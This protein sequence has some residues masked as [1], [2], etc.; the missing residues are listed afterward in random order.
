MKYWRKNI[1]LMCLFASGAGTLAQTGGVGS[2]FG[3]GIGSRDLALGGSNIAVCDFSTAPYWNPSR[4]ARSEQYSITG[5]HT[6]LFDT[7]V[8]YQ[9][10]GIVIPTLDWGAIGFGVTRLGIDGIEKRDA[11]NLLLDTIGDDRLGLRIGYGRA[12]GSLDVGLSLSLETHSLDTYKATSTP[13]LDIAATKMVTSP[14]RWC[15]NLS[16]TLVGRNVISPSMRLVDESVKSPFELQVGLSTKVLLSGESGNALGI[17]GGYS[18]AENALGIGSVGLECS[19]F[20][21]LKLRGSYRENH[22]STGAGISFTGISFDYA[23]VDRELGA[24]HMISLTTSVGKS[25]SERRAIRTQHR[26]AAFNRQMSDRLTRKNAEQASQLFDAGK[27]ALS[28]G[29]LTTADANLD[30]ALFLARG[31]GIDTSEYATLLGQVRQLVEQSSMQSELVRLLDSARA[32]L[33]AS[34][35]PSCQYFA[36]MALTLDSTSSEAK[37]LQSQAMQATAD[38]SRQEDFIQR[39]VWFIDSLISYGEVDQALS[40]ARSLNSVL[41][42]YPQAQTSLKKAEFEYYRAEA[43]K[44]LSARAYAQSLVLLDSALVRLPGHSRCLEL[45]KICRA[46]IRSTQLTSK[47]ATSSA[48]AL[49]REVLK[50]VHN[51]YGKAQDAFNRGELTQAIANWEEVEHLAPG[52]QSVRE[53]LLRAYRFVGIDLYGQNRL[54]E[55][56]QIWDKALKIAPENSE[57]AAYARRTRNEIEKLKALSYDN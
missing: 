32:R 38:A 18:K 1:L 23:L 24:L 46:E 13:G 44:E 22:L 28:A 43:E 37:S 17:T 16:F 4:L 10:V 9:Y 21:I 5:F 27:Q 57:I 48:P 2:P 6:R 49:S 20:D 55:A 29:D 3:M 26:E 35:Y 40:A 33:S 47:I 45:Q 41:G 34:D 54:S 25:V 19:L 51:T 12:I 14:F 56:L 50:Q 39:Q 11:S 8:T 7:D 15:E 52:Y 30:R 42:Q 36:G 53:Y 31:T